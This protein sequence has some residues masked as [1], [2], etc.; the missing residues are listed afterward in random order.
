MGSETSKLLGERKRKLLAEDKEQR[1]NKHEKR[2]HDARYKAPP[3]PSEIIKRYF[4]G[5]LDDE[6]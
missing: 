2:I 5:T 6:Q 3:K 1:L 4:E